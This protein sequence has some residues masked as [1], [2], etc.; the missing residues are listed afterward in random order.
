[1]LVSV[2]TMLWGTVTPPTPTPTPTS[3]GGN[4]RMPAK[5]RRPQEMMI[6]GMWLS[7]A[8][9]EEEMVLLLAGL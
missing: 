5:D 2:R 7:G 3:G 6:I 4:D 8:I 1:M 9:T